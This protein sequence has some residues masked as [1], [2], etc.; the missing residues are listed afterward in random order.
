MLAYLDYDRSYD[1]TDVI[2]QATEELG[3]FRSKLFQAI[4]CEALFI[5]FFFSK[6]SWAAKNGPVYRS[7]H[8]SFGSSNSFA[9]NITLKERQRSL[10]LSDFQ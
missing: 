7:E 9:H 10:P 6:F 4:F 1:R 5:F 3:V 8:F 2:I